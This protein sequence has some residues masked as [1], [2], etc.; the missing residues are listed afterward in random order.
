MSAVASPDAKDFTRPLSSWYKAGL[1]LLRMNFKRRFRRNQM[2]LFLEWISD[3]SDSK[4]LV[5]SF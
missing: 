3:F 2:E 5:S 1:E 4:G